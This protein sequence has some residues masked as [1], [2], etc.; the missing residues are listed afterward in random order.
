MHKRLYKFIEVHS[1]L[2]PLQFDF[3]E[4]HSTLHTLT[5]LTEFIKDSTDNGSY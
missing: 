1:L 2:H 5:S 3:R 4:K